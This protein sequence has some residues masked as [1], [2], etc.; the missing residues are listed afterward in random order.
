MYVLQSRGN[1]SR[2]STSPVE[3]S[4]PVRETSS[5]EP[6][7]L[8]VRCE[9]QVS[10]GEEAWQCGCLVQVASGISELDIL[11]MPQTERGN[12]YVIVFIDYLTKWVE[13]YGGGLCNIGPD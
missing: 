6:D 11:E 13:A 10:S 1:G 8:G 5:V 4:S 9:N 7:D 2:T 12:R 3:G